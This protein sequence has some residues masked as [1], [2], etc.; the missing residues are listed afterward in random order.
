MKSITSKYIITRR[1]ELSNE[2]TKYWN[3]IKNENVIPTGAKRNFDLKALILDIQAKAEER[4]L[5]KLYLQCINMGYKKFSEL[6][7]TNNYLDIFTLSEKQ[8]QL[9]HLSKIKTLD[10]KLKRAKGKKNLDKTEEL[11]SAYISSL[12]AKLQ[13]EI[14]ALNKKIEDFN[15]SA[16]LSIEEAPLSLAA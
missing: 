15:N 3:I 16:E 9:F 1:K 10:P 14:N 12:K 11:T 2:I 5:L 6:P 8:E 4:I 7:I 13:L